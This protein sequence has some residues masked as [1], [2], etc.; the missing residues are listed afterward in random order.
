MIRKFLAL[1]KEKAEHIGFKAQAQGGELELQVYDVIGSD[2]FGEGITVGNFSDAMKQAG[3]YQ[4]IKLKINSPGGDV[5]EAVAIYN[6]LRS[7]GKPVNVVVEGLAASAASIIAMAGD[8]CTMGE[9]SMMMIHNAMMMAFGNADEMR[10]CA[11]ILDT[12]SGS[13]ADIYAGCTEMPKANVQKLMDAETWMDAEDA[14]SKGFADDIAKNSKAAVSAS[15]NLAVYN[16]VPESLKAAPAPVAETEALPEAV[17]ED[18]LIDI[19]RKR[20]GMLRNS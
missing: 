2:F 4:S 8:K 7:C 18:P 10:K 13:I 15:F 9:G 6:L 3:D 20:L 12:V 14:V 16:N 11:D 17:E 5:F 19:F 1:R